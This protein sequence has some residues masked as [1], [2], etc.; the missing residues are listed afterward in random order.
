[1]IHVALAGRGRGR[2]RDGD[3]VRVRR[4][5]SQCDWLRS[6]DPKSRGDM[7]VD[8]ITWHSAHSTVEHRG[9]FNFCNVWPAK[10]FQFN[11]KSGMDVW[12]KEKWVAFGRNGVGDGREVNLCQ[13][14]SALFSGLYLYRLCIIVRSC[15]AKEGRTYNWRRQYVKMIRSTSTPR[16]VVGFWWILT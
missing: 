14:Y 8:N 3:R 10:E 16:L 15:S 5:M 1:M 4:E 12:S 11:F 7:H 9:S 13:V 2:G 6:L